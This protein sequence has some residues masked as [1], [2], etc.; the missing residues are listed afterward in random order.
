MRRTNTGTQ[1]QPFKSKTKFRK[2]ECSQ[3]KNTLKTDPM[4]LK[5]IGWISKSIHRQ[6]SI[7]HLLIGNNN[8]SNRIGR[9]GFGRRKEKCQHHCCNS[10][11]LW[12]IKHFRRKFRLVKW[13]CTRKWMPSLAT[14]TKPQKTICQKHI[15]TINLIA[16]CLLKTLPKVWQKTGKKSRREKWFE[17][18]IRRWDNVFE[19]TCNSL[20]HPP[21]PKK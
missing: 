4:L 5:R 18:N 20:L 17:K 8:Q 21:S 14:R 3:H 7:G 10:S 1:I 15:H 12:Q 13:V 19:W 11:K 16:E 9:L 6:F 2:R